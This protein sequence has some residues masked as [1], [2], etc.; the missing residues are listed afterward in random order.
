MNCKTRRKK[1]HEDIWKVRIGKLLLRLHVIDYIF[2]KPENALKNQFFIFFIFLLGI[3]TS[4][5]RSFWKFLFS[6]LGTSPKDCTAA[7]P[8]SIFKFFTA[9]GDAQLC[10]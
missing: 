1:H 3:L 9:Q 8:I 7:K 10:Y 5:L 6:Q 2:V 4:K